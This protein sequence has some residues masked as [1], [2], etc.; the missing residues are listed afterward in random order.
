MT[1]GATGGMAGTS[2]GTGG[3]APDAGADSGSDAGPELEGCVVARR[4][5]ECC[6]MWAAVSRADA[7]ADPCLHAIGEPLPSGGLAQGCT[8]EFCPDV[9]CVEEQ[10]P[11]RVAEPFGAS[12]E[13]GFA[14][15]CH[16]EGS[17]AVGWDMT[18]CCPCPGSQPQILIDREP[19]LIGETDTAND[20]PAVC[21]KPCPVECGVCPG[22]SPPICAASDALNACL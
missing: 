2:A 5:D 22:F 12:G 9:L 21:Y 1:G 10:P 3:T 13:C 18:S 16:A 8:P 20:L 15:E 7:Y 19:C 11:S 6:P 14:D 4:L 17:C